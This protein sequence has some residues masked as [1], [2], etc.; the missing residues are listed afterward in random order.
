[1]E[2]LPHPYS[3]DAL[4]AEESISRELDAGRPRVGR[5]I[6]ADGRSHGVRAYMHSSTKER[7]PSQIKLN[8]SFIAI[9]R[10]TQ[11]LVG[12]RS[13]AHSG[14]TSTKDFVVCCFLVDVCLP[15][16]AATTTTIATARS[17]ATSSARQTSVD[18]MALRS[19][20]QSA[21]RKTPS[22]SHSYIGTILLPRQARDKHREK[23]RGKAFSFSAGFVELHCSHDSSMR[24]TAAMAA[25]PYIDYVDYTGMPSTSKTTN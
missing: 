15:G 4:G 2:L 24:S 12:R 5:D 9:G 6:R 17:A 11:A 10:G 13:S 19:P 7:R 18:S 8:L 14:L 1:M 16:A 20:L 21:V 23:L 3:T 25:Q 22:L